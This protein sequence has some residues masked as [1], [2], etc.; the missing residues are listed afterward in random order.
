[1]NTKRKFLFGFVPALA[2]SIKAFG[3]DIFKAKQVSSIQNDLTETV[4]QLI[5]G[6][7]FI[8][9]KNPKLNHLIFFINDD[10]D[11]KTSP[12]KISSADDKI[13]GLKES[14]LLLDS[15]ASFALRYLGKNV[16]WQF[17]QI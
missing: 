2:V 16:G 13:N 15:N 8:L 11:W 10:V 5:P 4:V 1:M 9:P 14:S 7:N 17:R 12:P 3:L 6:Q